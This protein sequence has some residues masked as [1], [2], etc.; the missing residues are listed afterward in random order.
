M[1]CAS[2][3][4]DLLR[5]VGYHAGMKKKSAAVQLAGFLTK[6]TPELAARA[7]T[8]LAKMRERLPGA[9]EMVYDNYNALVIGFGPSER[10]AEAT[11]SIVVYPRW[12]T[13]CFLHGAKVSDPR[14]RLKGAGKQVRHITI[15]AAAML[16]TPE[17]EELIADALKRS[18]VPM[19]D[20]RPRRLIIKSISAK[21]RPRRPAVK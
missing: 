15:E 14:R 8:I 17:I 10:P 16:D 4:F 3:P 18:A 13:L 6:F 21:Q 2:G 12:I 20:S 5:K 1:I 19:G 7:R 11:F 9:V